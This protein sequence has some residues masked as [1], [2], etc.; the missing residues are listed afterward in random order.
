MMDGRYGLGRP[1]RSGAASKGDTEPRSDWPSS[2]VALLTDFYTANPLCS[3][4]RA[5]LL[6]GRLPIRNGFYT[7]NNHSRNAYTPQEIVGGIPDEELLI[8]EL[9]APAGYRNAIIGKWHL[10]HQEQFL[11]APPRLPRVF[12]V[13]QLP[14]RALRQRGAPQ[15]RRLQRFLHG[16]KVLRRLRD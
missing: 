1:G 15:H 9:L 2:R 13:A 10:G 11:P 6:T 7:T 3:P 4:S 16:W 5:A 8:P 14:P 12:R